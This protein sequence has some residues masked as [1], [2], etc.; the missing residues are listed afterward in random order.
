MSNQL[1]VMAEQPVSVRYRLASRAQNTLTHNDLATE[2]LKDFNRKNPL[3]VRSSEDIH[4]IGEKLEL[5][6]ETLCVVINRK[7][8]VIGMLHMKDLI[9]SLPM[10]LASQRGSAIADLVAQ[11]VMRPVWSLP[12]IGFNKLQNLTVDD[13]L[14]TFRELHSDYLLVTET[15]AGEEGKVVRGLLCADELSRRLGVPV[16]TTPRPESFSD[17]VHAVRQTL[18]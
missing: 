6:G 18:G 13:L 9:G 14:S 3:T 16:N 10:S 17:I 2:L 15:V 8:D 11:D 7:E 5:S 4:A 12:T 1:H